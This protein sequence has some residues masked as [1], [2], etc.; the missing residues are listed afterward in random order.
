MKDGRKED[1]GAP[2]RVVIAD[3][4]ALFREGLRTLLAAHHDLIV[5]GEAGD[6]NEAILTAKS[7]RA[8]V[9]L[10]D[11]KMPRL[12]GVAATKRLRVALPDCRVVALT[13]FDDDEYVFEALRAGA[14]GYLLKDASSERLVEAIRAAARGESF[15]QPSVA[16][17][18]VAEFSRLTPR[19]AEPSAAAVANLLS[20]RELE[21]IRLLVRGASNKEIAAALFV[22]EGTVKNHVTN[23][24][25]KL[26]VSDRTQA[27]L[28]ARELGLA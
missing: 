8:D 7:T 12:D 22:T 21:V 6:G 15:L 4:Q 28:R 3:D 13:T 14:V 11:M 25:T 17:K 5:V 16:S 18:V 9:V 1:G 20:E 23:V 2:I 19:A 10:M 27:A 24:L 26:K